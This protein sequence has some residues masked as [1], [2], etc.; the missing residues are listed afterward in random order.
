ML[1]SRLLKGQVRTAENYQI[2]YVKFH[3][4]FKNIQQKVAIK[5]LSTFVL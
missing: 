5:N 2:L 4:V 3:V 1:S